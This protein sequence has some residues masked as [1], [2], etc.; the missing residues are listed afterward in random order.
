MK[1]LFSL[2]YSCIMLLPFA[3]VA[4]QTY[5]SQVITA[6]EAYLGVYAKGRVTIK[7]ANPVNA[8]LTRPLIVAEGFD[9]G[10]IMEPAKIPF[11]LINNP[12]MHSP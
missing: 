1:K 12:Q 2:I 8:V 4:Q 10:H 6:S 11:E 3:V 7:Y 9:P 5:P